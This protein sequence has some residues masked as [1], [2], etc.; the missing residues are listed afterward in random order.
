MDILSD[1]GGIRLQE[2]EI[3]FEEGPGF[4]ESA[5][6]FFLFAAALRCYGGATFQLNLLSTPISLSSPR[7]FSPLLSLT[8]LSIRCLK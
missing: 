8:L 3:S 2:A 6:L 4:T 1:I 7:N 5:S